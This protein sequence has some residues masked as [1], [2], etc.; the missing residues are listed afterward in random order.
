ML[1]NRETT[2]VRSLST[3]TTGPCSLQLEESLGSNEDPEQL[4]LTKKKK[5]KNLKEMQEPLRS[6]LE[7]Q[8]AGREE[9]RS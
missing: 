8:G 4:K 6:Q 3:K 1:C 7:R 5:Q 2:A 9:G